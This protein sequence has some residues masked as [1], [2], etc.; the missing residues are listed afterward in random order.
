MPCPRCHTTTLLVDHTTTDYR[1]EL[2]LKCLLCG[3]EFP[4]AWKG[5]PRWLWPRYSI[6]RHPISSS[7]QTSH[8]GAS[9]S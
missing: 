9:S 1:G 5:V 7:S 3:R 6:A 4:V 8:L 2:V